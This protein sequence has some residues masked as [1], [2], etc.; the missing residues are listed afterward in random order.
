MS[1]VDCIMWWGYRHTNGT[2]QAKRYFGPEDI[3]EAAESD[4]VDE[5][6]GP[7]E[8]NGREKA[9]EELERRIGSNPPS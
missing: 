8:C 9:L 1:D 5:Y 3:I 4:F 2:L 7:F 6:Y